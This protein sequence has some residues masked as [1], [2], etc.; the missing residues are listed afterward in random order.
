MGHTILLFCDDHGPHTL[1]IDDSVIQNWAAAMWEDCCI[2]M[3]MAVPQMMAAITKWRA[4]WL[5]PTTRLQ[6]HDAFYGLF[7]FSLRA[8]RG[9]AT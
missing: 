4:N 7:T 6:L 1:H 3:V 2:P 9:H 8:E 5:G